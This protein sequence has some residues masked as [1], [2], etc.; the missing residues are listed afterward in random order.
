MTAVLSTDSGNDV[1][2]QNTPKVK[3]CTAGWA[4]RPFPSRRPCTAVPVS[5]PWSGALWLQ[6]CKAAVSLHVTWFS[7]VL[8]DTHNPPGKPNLLCL[9]KTF[10]PRTRNGCRVECG[11]IGPLCPLPLTQAQQTLAQNTDATW[12]WSIKAK[13]KIA[14]GSE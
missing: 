7:S 11:P 2:K 4:Q 1:S 3:E 12:K 5:R 14:Y 10:P 13:D 9:H 8:R 6:G